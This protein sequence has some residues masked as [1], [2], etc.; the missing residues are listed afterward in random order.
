MENLRRKLAST[1]M[2]A[3]LMSGGLAVPAATAAVSADASS[4]S[5]QE[6]RNGEVN[7]V[8]HQRRGGDWERIVVRRGLSI[9]R[10]ARVA[11]RQ[12]DLDERRELRRLERLAR[13]ADRSGDRVK[14]CEIDRRTHIYFHDD[15]R[16]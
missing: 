8:K 13:E 6:R 16:R 9:E 11:A 1:V 3:A 10:A 5:V 2:V 14:A 4:A 7:V 12:C 15:E